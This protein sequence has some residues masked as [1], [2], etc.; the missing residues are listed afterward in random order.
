MSKAF[1]GD[2]TFHDSSDVFLDVQ[3]DPDQAGFVQIM[4]GRTNNPGRAMELMSQ[5][6]P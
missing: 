4:Q 2:V 5:S 1:T 6:V 3:G